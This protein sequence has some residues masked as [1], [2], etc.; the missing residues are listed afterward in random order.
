MDQ[1]GVAD[2]SDARESDMRL[3]GFSQSQGQEKT[4][5]LEAGVSVIPSF[6]S[7]NFNELK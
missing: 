5:A 3:S 7:R 2:S 6:L 4:T 1:G